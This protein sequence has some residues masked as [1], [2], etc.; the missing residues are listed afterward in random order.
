MFLKFL[1]FSII[2]FLFYYTNNYLDYDYIIQYFEKLNLKLYLF[3]TQ[4]LIILSVLLS[5]KRLSLLINNNSF[6]KKTFIIITKSIIL[7]NGL[8]VIL[9]AR[10]S[11]FIK[12]FYLFKNSLVSFH[13]ALSILFLERLGDALIIFIF[14]AFASIF[15]I[16]YNFLLFNIIIMIS[17]IIII[18]LYFFKNLLF[19]VIN[20]YFP[21]KLFNFLNDI[22]TEF[23]HLLSTINLIK[24]FC[25]GFMIW[26][27]SL[28]NVIISVYFFNL[29][30][31]GIKGILEIFLGTIIA[32]AIPGMPGNF[33]TFESIVIFILKTYNVD[34][35]QSFIFSLCLHLNQLLLFISLTI[36]VLI[37]EDFNLNKSMFEIKHLLKK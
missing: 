3:I 16:E 33:V 32:G 5:T 26:L 29:E 13:K 36:L 19:E 7:S 14:S 1:K 24:F 18:L 17:L 10:L 11:E 15:F 6:N 2:I 21:F 22:S 4:P 27:L 23:Y 30:F 12:P 28:I 37:K 31:I 20:K 8:A 25:Y 9:P 35:N 34:F